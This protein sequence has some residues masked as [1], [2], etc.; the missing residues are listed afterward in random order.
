LFLLA[1]ELRGVG[2]C[3]IL[4]TLPTNHID[5]YTGCN[6]REVQRTKPTDTL[7]SLFGDLRK[8]LEWL[9]PK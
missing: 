6:S 3:L 7:S 2:A 5:P 1:Q 8:P 4:L 9:F